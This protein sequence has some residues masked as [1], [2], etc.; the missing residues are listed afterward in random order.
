MIDFP[1]VPR[2]SGDLG[3][4]ES[5]PVTFGAL[6]DNKGSVADDS[7]LCAGMALAGK[8]ESVE[9][10]WMWMDKPHDR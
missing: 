6:D 8:F 10:L 5:F 7:C 3:M 4:C 2:S 9:K 1:S